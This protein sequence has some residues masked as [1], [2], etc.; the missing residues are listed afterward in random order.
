MPENIGTT[1][2]SL[3]I[4]G[5][6]YIGDMQ[7]NIIGEDTPGIIDPARLPSLGEFDQGNGTIQIL[8]Y[9]F[10]ISDVPFT[11]VVR[12][13][14]LTNDG[15]VVPNSSIINTSSIQLNINEYSGPSVPGLISWNA[16]ESTINI[17]LNDSVTLH[18]GQEFLAF[19][20]NASGIA[21]N[22]GDVVYADSSFN[23]VTSVRLARANS[24]ATSR[25]TLGL[26]TQ[27]IPIG[28]YGFVTTMG[29]MHNVDTSAYTIDTEVYLSPT[30]AGKLVTVKPSSPNYIV[31]IGWIAKVSATDGE[32]FV[33]VH[34]VPNADEINYNNT[35]LAEEDQLLAT[36]VQ[37]AID[38]LQLRKADVGLLSSNINLYPT[39][40]PSDIPDYYRMVDSIDDD[41][42]NDP[43]FD[44]P[45]SV[46]N[47]NGEQ[48]LASL[49][50]DA[51]LFV[52][53]PGI[54]AVT[55]IGNIMKTSTNQN[56]FAEFLFKVFKRNS[57]G[58]EFLIAT[59]NTTGAIN[60]PNLNTYYEFSASA[61]LNNGV[62]LET[63][64]IVIKYY[65]IRIG[66]SCAYQFQ[67]G[68]LTPV[69]TLLPVPV[70]V[71][72]SADASGI[73]VD[74]GPFTVPGI[75]S[76]TDDNVQTALETIHLY[77]PFPT[78]NKLKD[79]VL[80]LDEN[81]NPIWAKF[82][83]GSKVLVGESAPVSTL[84]NEIEPGSLWYNTDSGRLFIYY[85]DG[86]PLNPS[87]ENGVRVQWVE[88]FVNKGDKGD[89]GD[90]GQN[91]II[92]SVSTTVLNPNQSPSIT[93]TG[94]P[95]SADF[96]FD[97]PRAAAVSL[98]T[99]TTLTPGSSATLTNTGS[100]G[101]TVLNFGIPRGTGITNIEDNEDGT[102][103]I[104][105]G[106]NQSV[107]FNPT[108][109][110]PLTAGN[111]G[112]ILVS[113]GG[114]SMPIWASIAETLSQEN[115]NYFK[116]DIDDTKVMQLDLSGI[117]TDTTITLTIPN[118]DGKIVLTDTT[119]STSIG[120]V[121]TWLDTLGNK[122]GTGY[123]V[124]TSLSSSTTALVRADAIQTALN[125]KANLES[126]TFT[127]TVGGITA[128]MVGLG[129]VDNTSDLGKP[130]S[131]ATQA[132][133]DL[134]TDKS[135]TTQIT[136]S[137]TLEVND[138]WKLLRANSSS[139]IVFTVP[140]DTNPVTIPN[141][142]EIHIFRYGTGEV[143]FLAGGSVTIRSE[144]NKL[145]INAQHQ[146]VTLK[147][148]A[149]NEWI[150]VGALKT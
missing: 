97:I 115:N 64:R 147:K 50:A 3:F 57:A 103:N 41:D 53:N 113:L 137:K 37:S 99:I 47:T 13:G 82:T 30:E 44:L 139:E 143:R 21:L 62:F 48:L 80:L 1:H 60:P 140:T 79:N 138:L 106:D 5:N 86:D 10:N 22:I 127:G 128:T 28:G 14:L 76:G 9:D 7:Y 72:P 142:S 73:L 40:A 148:I 18:V 17:K 109:F 119:L 49:A 67:F 56:H 16:A 69:R 83:S 108:G 125:L 39:N 101:D 107:V 71:I 77:D 66:G 91:A 23:G 92:N 89:T 112:Q 126:P 42:Y 78:T 27:P 74:V 102:I 54:I 136:L 87:E 15:A 129:N 58:D 63:D 95:V 93:N 144:S 135:I 141:D 24:V 2:G 52:G 36:N 38:E 68:G 104:S 134:K 19:V 81:L 65:A 96:K 116:D 120:N 149:T 88:I 117:D 35:I 105:Y 32:I 11:G 61:I 4:E 55:T 118:D 85:D 29:K 33:K 145:R 20:Y 123:T 43:A 100:N 70:S 25:T 130:I 131:T 51:N 150:L 8:G 75:F 90:P 84:E 31:D 133:L 124:Q 34:V 94:T 59:S 111:Q 12:G 45:I 6:L 146:A 122:L 121:P 114:T 98:G 26:V 132:A 46:A 110:Y